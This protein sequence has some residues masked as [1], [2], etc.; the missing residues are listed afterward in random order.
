[1]INCKTCGAGVSE[2]VKFCSQCGTPVAESMPTEIIN[3]QPI[4]SVN[5]QV[6]PTVQATDNTQIPPINVNTQSPPYNPNPQTP[7]YTANNQ[8]SPII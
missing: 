7:P 3:D 6:P 2:N 8:I 5:V 4:S 1:M